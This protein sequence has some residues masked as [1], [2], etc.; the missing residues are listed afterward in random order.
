M[1][2]TDHD[3]SLFTSVHKITLNEGLRTYVYFVEQ[4]GLIQKMW[5]IKFSKLTI[6]ERWCAI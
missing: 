6:R 5:Y 1:N 3:Y 2:I 4:C